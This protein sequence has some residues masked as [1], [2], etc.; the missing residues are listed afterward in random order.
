LNFNELEQGIGI[1]TGTLTIVAAGTLREGEIPVRLKTRG[2]G[3]RVIC[4]TRGRGD[5]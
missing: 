3:Y 5:K 4:K 1:N 2:Q